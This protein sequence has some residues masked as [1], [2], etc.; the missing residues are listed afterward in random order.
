M[1]FST[2]LIGLML[3]FPALAGE[4]DALSKALERAFPGAKVTDV[5]ETPVRDIR[6]VQLN[7]VEWIYASA[8]GRYVFSG[9]M[10][11]IRGPQDIV[12][13]TEQRMQGPRKQALAKLD[14]AKVIT[15]EAED[16]KAS[17][18]VFTDV[19]CGYCQRLHRQIANY[20]DLGITVHYLAFPRG[21]ADGEAADTM[22]WVWCEKDRHAALTAAKLQGV[23]HTPPEGCKDPV[24]EQFRMGLEFGVRGTPAI[25]TPDGEYL[26][27]YLNPI[28]MAVD[29]GLRK[30]PAEG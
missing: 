26:G 30:P 22:R 17:V 2:A 24:E 21:G 20:N 4:N 6:H 23:T 16:E 5:V 13:V 15:Y 25:Y 14:P 11:E 9:D 19:T 7:G 10:L 8:D 12:S 3:T 1:R 18:Y 29:L 27:G 28:D